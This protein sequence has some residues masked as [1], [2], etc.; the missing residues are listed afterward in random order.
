MSNPNRSESSDWFK[1]R[2]DFIKKSKNFI[3]GLLPE[4]AV[5]LPFGEVVL[6]LRQRLGDDFD[7]ALSPE[8][9]KLENGIP[10][11]WAVKDGHFCLSKDHQF[12][13]EPQPSSRTEEWLKQH[14]FKT[15]E[16]AYDFFMDG[17]NA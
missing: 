7:L 14:R 8:A 9:T 15:A 10:T 17:K 12:E 1:N 11:S 4:R 16:E 3:P 5:K 13:Y 6:I 2:D